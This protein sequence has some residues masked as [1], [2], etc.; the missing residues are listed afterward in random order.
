M[1]LFMGSLRH[2]SA[3][4]I[5]GN[6]AIGQDTSTAVNV[7]LKLLAWLR[8]MKMLDTYFESN[9]SSIT[10]DIQMCSHGQTHFHTYARSAA[11]LSWAE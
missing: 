2:S 9:G 10:V 11:P 1:A 8:P 4:N 3:V 7:F 5:G 6:V